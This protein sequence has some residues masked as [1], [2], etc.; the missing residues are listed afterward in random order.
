MEDGGW[1]GKVRG[2]LVPSV[3][4]DLIAAVRDEYRDAVPWKHF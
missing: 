2:K 1:R 3:D 4:V